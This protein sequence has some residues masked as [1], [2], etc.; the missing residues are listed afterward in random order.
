VSHS[1][2]AVWSIDELDFGSCEIRGSGYN[3]KVLELDPSETSA[4]DVRRAEENVV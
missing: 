1:L 4:A 2:F 3:I